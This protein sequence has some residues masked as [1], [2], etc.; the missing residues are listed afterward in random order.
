VKI[1]F[2]EFTKEMNVEI[3]K[4]KPCFV[5]QVIEFLT[6]LRLSKLEIKNINRKRRNGTE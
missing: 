2:L 3:Y 4:M 5:V 1:E 6:F